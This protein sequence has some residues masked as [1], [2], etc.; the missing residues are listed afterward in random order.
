MRKL[1][2]MKEEFR[3]NSVCLAGVHHAIQCEI[4][5]RDYVPLFFLTHIHARIASLD[6]QKCL[7]PSR[8]GV[9]NLIIYFLF[10][11]FL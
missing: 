2:V 10:I 11:W 3:M 4:K 9:H 8:S 1:R 6:Q 7:L 5:S